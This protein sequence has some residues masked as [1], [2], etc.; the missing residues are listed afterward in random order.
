ML[1]CSLSL[2]AMRP[3]HV[4]LDPV[5]PVNLHNFGVPGKTLVVSLAGQPSN[6]EGRMAKKLMR[7]FGGST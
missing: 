3:L 1:Q 6:T 7:P 5:P 4:A 2:G